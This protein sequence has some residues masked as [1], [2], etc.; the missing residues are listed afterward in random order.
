MQILYTEEDEHWRQPLGETMLLYREAKKATGF[1]DEQMA[2]TRP[3]AW[4]RETLM[5][6]KWSAAE[7]SD[8][9]WKLRRFQEFGE[10]LKEA[11]ETRFR[12]EWRAYDRMF[13]RMNFMI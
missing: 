8:I 10:V 2:R 1:T 7:V 5:A 6:A 4:S 9:C 11:I 3:A 13:E 12:P